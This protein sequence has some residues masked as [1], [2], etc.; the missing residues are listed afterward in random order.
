MSRHIRARLV[1]GGYVRG[2]AVA[3]VVPLVGIRGPT[4]NSLTD[5]VGR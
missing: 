3:T 4:G 5:A 1:G 2:Q